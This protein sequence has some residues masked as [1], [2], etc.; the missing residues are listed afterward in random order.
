MAQIKRIQLRGISRTPSDR[1]TA[2]GGC[3]ESLN[4]YLDN[5]EIAPVVKPE[6]IDIGIPEGT[7]HDRIFIHKTPYVENYIAIDSNRVGYYRN[8]QYNSIYILMDEVVNDITSVGNTLVI[9]TDKRMVY[10]VLKG[11][12]YHV[13]KESAPEISLSFVNVDE[14]AAADTSAAGN[15]YAWDSTS[16]KLENSTAVSLGEPER[17][18]EVYRE[19]D[20]NALKLIGEGYRKVIDHNMAMGCFNAPILVRYAVTLHDG[21]MLGASS[22][23]LLG[24]GFND[25]GKMMDRPLVVRGKIDSTEGG[26]NYT[27]RLDFRSPF[28]IGVYKRANDRDALENWRDII[29]SIDVYVSPMVDLYPNMGTSAK[30]VTL[31]EDDEAGYGYHI[32]LDPINSEDEKQIEKAVLS[33]GVFYKIKSYSIDDVLNDYINMDVLYGNYTGEALWPSAK[34]FDDLK[35]T[36]DALPGK[37]FTY[38]NS[39]LGLGGSVKLST[40]IGS[41]HGQHAYSDAP[42]YSYA[43]R[44]HIRSQT[45]GELIVYSKNLH[46]LNKV[47]FLSGSI[48]RYVYKSGQ[49]NS[50]KDINCDCVGLI[51]YPDD[52]CYQV[53]VC[54]M[55]SNWKIL[56]VCTLDMRPHP[57][58]PMCSYAFIGLG[59]SLSSLTYTEYTGDFDSEIPENRMDKQE[60]KILASI[61]DNPFVFPLGK[62]YTFQGKVLNVATASLAM[63][64]GQFGQFPIYAFTSEG[65]WAMELDSEGTIISNKPLSREVCLSAESITSI[66]QAVV[67]VTSKG[68][69]LLQGSEVTDLSPYMNG[70]HYAIEGPSESIIEGQAGFE[71]MIPTL[72]DQTPFMA[73]MRNVQIGYDYAGQR[74]VCINPDE[75]YQYIYKLDTQTWHKTFYGESIAAP[76]NSYP[77]CLALISDNGTSRIIDL[78]TILDSSEVQMTEKGVIATRPFDLG[79]PDVF[80]TIT[81]IRVRGQFQKGSVNFILLGSND[82]INFYTIS[83]LRGKAWKQFRIILLSKLSQHERISWIDVQYDTKFTNRLR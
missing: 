59:K 14:F 78:S 39:V 13:I 83:T 68:L 75:E 25:N 18:Y 43:F 52:R 38:N 40:G 45:S 2:D 70:K 27:F 66:D 71:T 46:Y 62:R 32:I 73:F 10:A 19:A 7:S 44:Y 3:A 65:V 74:L 42:N 4:V 9:A 76:V 28:K 58:V 12:E 20:I 11:D 72:V 6:I 21:S 30:L 36:T 82:G 24:G 37:L 51:T 54:E 17:N 31:K 77:E 47:S 56:G 55:D 53:D 26:F 69:M 8:K 49:T 29:S 41:L 15:K 60:N 79:E 1:L 67:Y 22:P 16:V 80:K 61:M 50:K 63:S 81:D 35:V 23:I 48:G 64:Q 5:D 33:Q 34:R 57:L